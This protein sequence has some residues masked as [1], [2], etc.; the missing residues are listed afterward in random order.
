MSE[1]MRSSVSETAEQCLLC[2]QHGLDSWEQKRRSNVGEQTSSIDMPLTRYQ[3]LLW[4]A[5]YIDSRSTIWHAD[6]LA[7][8]PGSA[9]FLFIALPTWLQF[10]QLSSTWA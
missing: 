2:G 3:K 10:V 1:D 6:S 8:H 5:N 7:S 9:S 4:P